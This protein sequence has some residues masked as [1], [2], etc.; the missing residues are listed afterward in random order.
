MRFWSAFR[1]RDLFPIARV[2]IAALVL[3]LDLAIISSVRNWNIVIRLIRVAAGSS[4][5]V[6]IA[7]QFSCHYQCSQNEGETASEKSRRTEY[8][9]CGSEKAAVRRHHSRCR[10]SRQ[11]LQKS[12]FEEHRASNER[13][14]KDDAP[15]LSKLNAQT[16]D[17]TTDFAWQLQSNRCLAPESDRELQTLQGR[18][19]TVLGL[20]ACLKWEDG[21][22]AARDRG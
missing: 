11:S 14:A 6:R 3:I 5:F 19:L 15:T 18:W 4:R 2:P 22:G 7:L 1:S 9:A 16:A 17:L 10:R 12:Y 8:F 21:R 20:T 13:V